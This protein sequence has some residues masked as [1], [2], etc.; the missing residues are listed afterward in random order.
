[1]DTLS[2][3]FHVLF[4]AVLVGPQLLLFYAVIPSTWLIED[5]GLRRSVVQVVTRRFGVLSGISLVGLL[6]TGLYQFYSDG[7]VP[8]GIQDEMM[9]Y[10]WGLIFSTKMTALVILVAL[11]GVHGMVF[12]K[13]IRLASEAVQRGEG[14]AGALEAARR[15]SMI[16]SSLILLVSIATMFL[17]VT[18]GYAGY[19][20]VPR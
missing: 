2:L 12:G 4:A 20:E 13:R 1:M 15:T 10:R 19:S 7:I 8:Q 6:I 5:E 17:G 16:F 11:I 9:D 3:C 18:L 14:D